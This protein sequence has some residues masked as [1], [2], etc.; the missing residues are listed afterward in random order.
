MVTTATMRKP[1]ISHDPATETY[2]PLDVA[3]I[4]AVRWLIKIMFRD[5]KQYFH[6]QEFH[7]ETLSGASVDLFCELIA[8]ILANYYHRRYRIR[9][10]LTDATKVIRNYWNLSLTENR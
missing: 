5:L 6:V 10:S 7:N 9:G 2:D 8:C 1:H 4:Y 3:L